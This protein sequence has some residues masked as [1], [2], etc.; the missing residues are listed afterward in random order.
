MLDREGTARP[1]RRSALIDRE[2]ERYNVDIAALSETRLADVGE[3]PE[4][5]Y[6]F[7]WSGKP[8]AEKREA[9]VGFAIRSKLVPSLKE[10]PKAI[11]CRLMTV[12]LALP[13]Q[14]CATLISV[15]APT[16]QHS[17]ESKEEF[18][19]ELRNVIDSVPR[20][21]KLIILG[22]FNARVGADWSAWEGV[23]GKHGVGKCNAN[24]QLLLELCM[25][26]DLNI[27]NTTFQLPHR[28]RTSWMHPRSK[29]WHLIDYILVRQK[30]KADVRVTKSMCGADCWTDHRL[31]ISKMKFV[32][33]PPKRPQGPKAPKKMDAAKLSTPAIKET[34]QTRLNGVLENHVIDP[35]NIGST[36]QTFSE[37]VFT[38]SLDAIGTPSR[39]HQDWFDDQ[40]ADI[41]LLLERKHQLHRS[42]QDDPTSTPKRDAFRNAKQECQRELR[43]MQNEWFDSKAEEIEMHSAGNNSKKFYSSLKAVYGRQAG[44]GSPPLL[45]ASGTNLITDKKKILERWREHFDNVLNRPSSANEEAINRLPQVEINMSLADVPSLEEVNKAIS[46]LS[47]GKAPGSDGIP[48][49]VFANGGPLLTEKL[50]ELFQLMWNGDELPQ[51]FKD[52]SITHLYKNKGNRRIC[53]NHRGISLLEIA[54][55]ILARICLNRLQ[56]HL[57]CATEDAP[58]DVQPSLLPESQCG[59]R[60]ARGTVDMIFTVR[61]LQEKSREQNKGLFITFVDLTKAF[62][63]VNRD[64]LWKIMSKFGCPEKFVNI[65]RLFHDGMQARVKDD[66]QYSEP[67]PV[68]NGVKQGCV[69]APTL[70]SMLFSAMLTDAFTGEDVGIE[71][72]SR[73]DGGFYKPQRLKADTKVMLDMLRDL[74]FA[75]DCAL[76]ASSERE[77]QH[78]VD[79][80]SKACKN[81]G[82][83]ISIPKTEVLFQPAPGEPHY[84][85]VITI[86][87]H[88]LANT[89]KF[90]YLG[91]TMSNTAT[92]DEEINLRLARAS[93]SFG[94]LSDR[95]WK[96]RGLTCKT[97]LKVYHAVVLPSLLY[98]SETWTVYSRHLQ[99]LQSFH[100]RCLRQILKVKW[101]DR[102]SNTE[103]LQRANSRSISSMLMEAQLRWSGHV[104]RMPDY[105]LPKRVFFG[106]L[107]S[108]SRSR[109][110]PRLRYKDTLK[111]ALKRCNIDSDSW[112]ILAQ[113][114]STWRG[115]VKRGVSAYEQEFI[116]LEVDKRKRRKDR[117]ATP[118]DPSQLYP[119]P[120][121]NR[122]FRAPIAVISHLRTRPTA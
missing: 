46:S 65:V 34:L 110:R 94:R 55:K 18:Y 119:C 44:A 6:T 35:G 27:T 60:Q 56:K 75:D 7:F 106:E 100:L 113:D 13:Q 108:G 21:D 14:R 114:R 80:F 37:K 4:S 66:G 116:A 109:G 43:R 17:D 36:W 28:N 95:V 12:R 89:D 111:A 78:M 31:I 82:L 52:P 9:G 70:F 117:L 92:I 1:E 10:K 41:K 98:G 105:R 62:D 101:Q 68:T 2:L 24:G 39:H 103:I 29:H 58:P 84:D 83:T 47:N 122:S 87:G 11:N 72:R 42:H 8:A 67:F 77:M 97:K 93:A 33:Q 112:E 3:E 25:T 16:L 38:A 61:Q 81:F 57:E 85:P 32:L 76:C 120:H 5:T 69:L 23:L 59:F 19:S 91:S 88:K 26:Y 104:A 86:D 79:L 73:T 49:E 71:L 107:N 96:K 22:D 53:D 74:L 118:T 48:A 30:D 64:A 99:R 15:Y 51:S 102:V 45:D 54:G 20:Q 115:L 121:C 40:N 63:T 50:L 90:P